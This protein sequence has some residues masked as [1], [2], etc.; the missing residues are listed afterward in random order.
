MN[1]QPQ[2]E[3]DQPIASE[4]EPLNDMVSDDSVELSHA[5]SFS[6]VGQDIPLVLEQALVRTLEALQQLELATLQECNQV[7]ET[8]KKNWLS[9]KGCDPVECL[10]RLNSDDEELLDARVESISA[11]LAETLSH[12]PTRVP[13]AGK[14]ITPNSLYEKNPYIESICKLMGVPVAYAEDL[15]VMALASINPYFME[16]LAVTI[17]DYTMQNLGTQP[18]IS[19]IRLDY[20][21]WVAMYSKHFREEV[22]YDRI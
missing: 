8:V 18:I 16:A 13:F 21:S 11:K 5:H 14:L 9:G 4:Q 6:V 20:A 17:S 2:E 3:G 12:P 15:D 7:A 19:T 22:D 10:A 1:T